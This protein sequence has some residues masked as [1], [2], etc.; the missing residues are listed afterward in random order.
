MT[1]IRESEGTWGQRDDWG[2]REQRR[3]WERLVCMD[4]GGTW[5]FLP[6]TIDVT[7]LKIKFASWFKKDKPTT[8]TP[9]FYYNL[10]ELGWD[11]LLVVT[12][13]WTIGGFLAFFFLHRGLWRVDLH[14]YGG[15]WYVCSRT[16]ACMKAGI[17]PLG[18]DFGDFWIFD[19]FGKHIG[20]V[21][22][23]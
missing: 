2:G 7:Y 20:F 6:W 12:P 3:M 10:A 11:K 13:L 15:H 22:V 23:W 5:V 17:G 19:I 1:A 21:Y 8:R 18:L 16:H 9:I 4:K 14:D